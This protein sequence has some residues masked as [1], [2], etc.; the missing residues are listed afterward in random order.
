MQLLQAGSK[1]SGPPNKPRSG[2][3]GQAK[4]SCD[5]L[6]P[7]P[8]NQKQLKQLLGVCGFYSRFIVNYATYVEFLLPL[9]RIQNKCKWTSEKQAAFEAQSAQF[10]HSIYLVH[11]GEDLPCVINTDASE[12]AIVDYCCKSIRKAKFILFGLR[13]MCCHQC[14][15]DIRHASRNYSQSSTS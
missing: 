9:L 11:P 10:A 14:S 2:N 13:R 1:I 6:L 15:R 7:A 3:T 4:D 5:T 12:R 8:R